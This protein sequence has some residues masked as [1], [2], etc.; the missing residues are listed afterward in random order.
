MKM[1]T[2]LAFSLLFCLPAAFAFLGAPPTFSHRTFSQLSSTQSSSS[3]MV[4]AHKVLGVSWYADMQEIKT[5]YRRLAKLYHPGKILLSACD[6]CMDTV[7]VPSANADLKFSFILTVFS[8]RCQP[9][10]RH[11]G[12]VSANQSSLPHTPRATNARLQ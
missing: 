5:A 1:K 4:D 2:R 10:Q 3:E 11:D 6:G 7:L 12:T 9:W 8:F